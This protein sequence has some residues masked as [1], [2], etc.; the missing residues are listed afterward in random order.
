MT[1]HAAPI[2]SRWHIYTRFGQFEASREDIITF[3][4]GVPGFEA[5]RQFVLIKSDSMAP[6][7]CLQAVEPPYPSFLVIDPKLVEPEYQL[8]LGANDRR[9]LGGADEVLLRLVIVASTDQGA[10]VNLRA[11]VVINTTQMVGYQVIPEESSY[12]LTRAL[13]V[14]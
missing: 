8:K 7:K 2:L 1:Q 5:C 12:P 6:L 14:E 4:D 3:P 9:R 10:S 13:D 11:P